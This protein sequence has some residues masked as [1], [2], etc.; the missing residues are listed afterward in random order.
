MTVTSKQCEEKTLKG[1]GGEISLP[2]PQTYREIR[3]RLKEKLQDGEYSV[4]EQTVPRQYTKLVS[5]EGKIAR[6]QFT[7]EGRKQP[8]EEIRKHTFDL[9]KQYVRLRKD[10]EYNNMT[11]D[12]RIKILKGL[13]EFNPGESLDVTKKRLMNIERT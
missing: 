8:L 7:V 3:R 4:G 12:T 13:D 2:I 6:K 10:S 9:Q 5:E 11:V 1:L